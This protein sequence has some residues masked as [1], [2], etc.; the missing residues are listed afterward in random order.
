MH[1]SAQRGADWLFRANRSDGRFVYG[2]LPAVNAP[3]EIAVRKSPVAIDH[4]Q[5]IAKNGGAA[6]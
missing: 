4:R 1:L 5:A 3:L 6:G 2:F